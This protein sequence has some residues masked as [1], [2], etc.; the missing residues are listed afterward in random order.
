[1]SLDV[2]RIGPGLNTDSS[3]TIGESKTDFTGMKLNRDDIQ[4]PEDST[5][6]S[7]LA[8]SGESDDLGQQKINAMNEILQALLQPQ[9]GAA[10][11]A[12][13][14]NGQE[15]GNPSA[16]VNPITATQQKEPGGGGFW[17]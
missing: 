8:K 2:S 13:A 11:G 9:N 16:Q 10:L 17:K 5:Q 15:Q 12:F 6:L 1:M 7:P 14:Q 3:N 4:T